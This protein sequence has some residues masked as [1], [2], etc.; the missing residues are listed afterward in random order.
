M[1]K[2]YIYKFLFYNKKYNNIFFIK[3]KLWKKCNLCKKFILIEKIKKNFYICYKCKFHFYIPFKKRIET[4]FEKELFEIYNDLIPLDFLKFFDTKHYYSK[5]AEA[6]IKTNLIEAMSAFK[7]KIFNINVVACV[8]EFKFIGG[9]LNQIIGNKFLKVFNFCI[10][11]K[12]PL[13]CFFT[14][15]GARIQESIISLMQMAK[16]NLML[17]KLKEKKIPYISILTNPCMGGMSASLAMLGDINIAEP[18]SLIGFTGPRVIEK[19]F[20]KKIKTKFQESEFLLK[21]G[22]I[23]LI[24]NRKKI[25]KKIYNILKIL[26]NNQ[27]LKK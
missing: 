26:I 18:K 6:Q 10:K 21:N 13:I 11:N 17:N 4:I 19:F 20:G 5:I 22:F 23:D 2:E 16:I 7:G 24:I 8:F 3:F 15:G 14:S 25:K 9:S 1:L 27:G 12:L